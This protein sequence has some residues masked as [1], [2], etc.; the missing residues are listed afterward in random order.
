MRAIWRD[1]ASAPAGVVATQAG[2]WHDASRC[3]RVLCDW[4]GQPAEVIT[5]EAFR[6]MKRG[7]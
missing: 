2:W 5:D 6:A 1:S 4:R 3:Q 7:A